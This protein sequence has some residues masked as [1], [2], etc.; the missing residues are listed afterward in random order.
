MISCAFHVPAP[1]G[2]EEGDGGGEHEADREGEDEG[3]FRRFERSGA[4]SALM[5]WSFGGASTHCAAL[6]YYVGQREHH[7]TWEELL[8]PVFPLQLAFYSFS[9]SAFHELGL[10]YSLLCLDDLMCGGQ[11]CLRAGMTTPNLQNAT[12]LSLRSLFL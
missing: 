10:N 12:V 1:A 11:V 4:I 6:P 2:R 7:S 8:C 9:T 3:W 5:L